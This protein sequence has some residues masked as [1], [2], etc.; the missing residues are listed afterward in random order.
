MTALELAK[1]VVAADEIDEGRY[2]YDDAIRALRALIRAY[3]ALEAR[4]LTVTVNVTG[5]VDP[6]AL[7]EAIRRGCDEAKSQVK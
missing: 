7:L 1:Y 6:D 5:V 3:E 4:K 2:D